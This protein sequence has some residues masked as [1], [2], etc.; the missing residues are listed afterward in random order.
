MLLHGVRVQSAVLRIT[1]IARA[2]QFM[3]HLMSFDTST[4][5]GRATGADSIPLLPIDSL[6]TPQNPA[7]ILKNSPS[8]L[9]PDNPRSRRVLF[10][11]TTEVVCF[12]SDTEAEETHE[13]EQ[14]LWQR[15]LADPAVPYV[16]LLYLQLFLNVVIV[17]ALLYLGYT[18]VRTVRR[19]IAHRVDMYTLDAVHEIL[20]CLREYYRNRCNGHARAPALEHSCTQWEKCMNRDPQ[21]LGRARVTAET[22]ADVVNGFVRPLSWKLVAVFCLAFGGGLGAVNIGLARCRRAADAMRAPN[23]LR[24]RTRTVNVADAHD[25]ESPLRARS[26]IKPVLDKQKMLH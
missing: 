2:I 3:L 8:H 9:R 21:Q 16:L 24:T 6:V 23:P 10:S 15:I 4:P 26:F 14:S 25:E 7:S 20:R 13:Q 11:P 12:A 1:S 22:L 19:D 18:F 5:I 17:A